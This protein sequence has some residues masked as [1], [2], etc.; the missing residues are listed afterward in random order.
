MLHKNRHFG[1]TVALTLALA[2]ISAAPAAAL[3]DPG[4]QG[5]LVQPNHQSAPSVCSEVC[6][7]GGYTPAP[8]AKTSSIAVSHARRVPPTVI[9]T[10][11]VAAP[12]PARVVPHTGGFN[13]GDAAI[14]AGG[15]ITILVLTGGVLMTSMRRSRQLEQSRATLVG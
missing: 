15:M 14:G 8:A 10:P 11:L 3:P 4:F 2:A 1:L 9:S 12:A 13:W 5:P 7:S 6:S